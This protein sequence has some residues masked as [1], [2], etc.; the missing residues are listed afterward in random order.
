MGY[1]V[2]DYTGW[3]GASDN[4]YN[5]SNYIRQFKEQVP[6]VE[7]HPIVIT[8]VD[9]SPQ[10]SNNIKNYNEMGQPVYGNYGTWATASTSKWGKAYKA[11]LD[12]YGNISMTLSGTHCLLDV[13]K[14]I[15]DGTV[16]PAF[17]GLEEAERSGKAA[18]SESEGVGGE[19]DVLAEQAG[20][21][22]VIS[23]VGSSDHDHRR[24][25]HEHVLETGPRG[26]LGIGG[27]I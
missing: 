3:Y 15:A 26:C 17:G 22:S 2:H 1:A 11:I 24:S 7:T 27:L 9:W 8:E 12:Y 23:V 19:H 10:N 21:N 6:V 20:V 18:G 25:V 5:T 16:T 14:L 4:S 13:N